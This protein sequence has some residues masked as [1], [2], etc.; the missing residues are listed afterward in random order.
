MASYPS[1]WPGIRR[2]PI[3][4]G[5]LLSFAG[6]SSAH[7]D[8]VAVRER[9]GVLGGKSW[10]G[11][12]SYEKLSGTVYFAVDPSNP[13]NRQI[14]D[15]DKAPRN[16]KGKVEFSA[17]FYILR[18][19]SGGNGSLLLE[20]PNRGGKGLLA[21]V[22]D[23]KGSTDPT[24]SAE[25]G[26]AFLLRKGF[27][28]AWLGWQWDVRNEPGLMRLYAPVARNADGSSIRGLVRA[29]WTPSRLTAEWPL[30][31]V[32]EG[33]IGG[34]G[35]PVADP[36]ANENVLTVRD[37]AICSRRTIPR[38]QWHFAREANGRVEPSDRFVRLDGGFL[39]GKIYEIVYT[40]K[41]PVVAGLGLAATRDFVSYLK[42]DPKAI[43]PVKRAEAL[44]I[45]QDGR[46]LRHF[47]WQDFNADEVGRKALDGVL[48]MVAG[49]GR[50]SFNY[51]FAQPSRDSEPTSSI[52]FPTDLFPFT[53]RPERDPA[54]G[55][56]AGLLDAARRSN[57]VPRIFFWNTSFEYWGRAASLIHTTPDGGRDVAPGPDVRIYFGAGQGHF[58]APFPPRVLTPAVFPTH[59]GDLYGQQMADPNP[60]IWIWHALIVDMDE[61][62]R[63]GTP[64]PPSAYPKIADGT[65]VPVDTLAFPKIPG[66]SVARIPVAA[67]R[68]DFGRR[69]P[70]G[71][72]TREPPR[73]LGTYKVLVPQV[74]RDG[75]DLTGI[76]TPE[77]AVPLATYTGWNLRNPSIGMPTAL[78]PFTGSYVPL[79]RTAAERRRTGDPRLSVE[80]R[81]KDRADYLARYRRAARRLV[82][83]RFLLEEDLPTIMS[84]GEAEWDFAVKTQPAR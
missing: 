65:L 9:A 38:R 57:T 64:P 48:S 54:T 33:N 1:G 39:P 76:H 62:V 63:N 80:Q 40:A 42:Y 55:Q 4:V 82:K 50:G 23:A 34:T 8:H 22:Q 70:Q 59:V 16:A 32:I 15:L 71:I 47:L 68:L 69:W 66:V 19:K 2:L 58:P 21:V 56:V 20:V 18:P 28:I 74:D 67:Y 29:D 83:A 12:G 26:D 78:V 24:T 53:D 46:F 79:P 14:V 45:S 75:I 84:R 51:R 44:G 77:L 5:L 7:V 27:T 49:A 73:V 6:A 43:A 61:W 17:D 72:I 41:D 52:F 37:C 36:N 30:G 10:G 35:Y 81:Y 60:R 31:H 11:S 13:H 3:V 25:F